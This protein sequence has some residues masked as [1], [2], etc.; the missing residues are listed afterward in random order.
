MERDTAAALLLAL[1]AVLVV[2]V[3]AATLENPAT[4]GGDG[5]ASEGP[6]TATAAGVNE[7]GQPVGQQS[8]WSRGACIGWLQS[9]EVKLLVLGVVSGV[10]L[11]AY[12]RTGLKF[13]GLFTLVF[14]GAPVGVAWY[15]LA[16]CYG[17]ESSQNAEAD[18]GAP[19][20]NE[21]NGTGANGL[22]GVAAEAANEPS[23]ALALLL[24]VLLL[25]AIVVVV[26]ASSGGDHETSDDAATEDVG[27][28]D[29]A[30]VGRAAGRAADRI[31]GEADTE[32]EVHRA[33][34]EMTEHL[35]VDH[36]ESST[37]AEFAEAAVDAGMAP[38]DVRELTHLF[39][40]VRYGGVAVTAQREKRAV[41]ALRRIEDSYAEGE[42]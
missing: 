5:N 35:A 29:V 18:P 12:R 38:D 15:A 34:V 42:P 6:G 17:R 11:L 16:G 25:A 3:A 1:L 33:W 32:N 14:W 39:E 13:I 7:T 37:P 22:D 36:P 23:V 27:S 21:T 20:L 19:Q 4:G 31:A 28:P 2:G 9:I 10:A 30:E 26:F 24:G 41:D 40:E 8:A